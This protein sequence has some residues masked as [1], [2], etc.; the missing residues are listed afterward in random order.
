MGY[1]SKTFESIVITFYKEYSNNGKNYTSNL[2]YD[3]SL[4]TLQ[5]M[6]W[7]E[8]KAAKKAAKL[9]QNN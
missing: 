7:A 8:E 5:Q 2:P 4:S 3:L 9:Q 6:K 1:D